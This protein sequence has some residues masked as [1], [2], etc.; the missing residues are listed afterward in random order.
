MLL[1]DGARMLSR[2]RS[3]VEAAARLVPAQY[4]YPILLLLGSCFGSIL[5]LLYLT[6]SA[7]DRMEAQREE[8]AIHSALNG[9]T[10]MVLHDL[11]DYAKWDDAVRH[12][13]AGS[14]DAW[15]DDNIT[16]FLG[17]IQGYDHVFVI[18]PQD[19]THYAFSHHVRA[20]TD[21]VAT[22]GPSFAASMK[23]VRGMDR[24]GAPI[25][26][27]FARHGDVLYLYAVAAVVPLTGKVSLPTGPTY[28]LAIAKRVDRTFLATIRSEQHLPPLT[29]DLDPT[30]SPA[31][32][33]GIAIH[34]LA[35]R[36]LATI[37]LV[38]DRPGTVLRNQVIPGFIAIACLALVAA[39]W[40]LRHGRRAIS[41]LHDSRAEAL[42]HANHDPLTNLPNRRL[43]LQRV[44][45]AL[46]GGRSVTLLY[47]DLDGFKDVNDLFG[48]AM[49][50]HLL[51]ET[52]DRLGQIT[53]HAD[54]IA[55]AGGD[56]FA[57]LL[58]DASTC[59]ADAIA[60][61][62]AELFR[63]PFAIDTS[64]VGIG[65]S[66]GVAQSADGAVADDELIR[67]ADV[68][69]YAAKAAGKNGWR[70][71]VPDMDREHDLR[72]SM[73][74]DLRGA[75]LRDEITVVFQPIVLAGSGEVVCVEALARW[76]HPNHGAVPPDV[77]IPLAEKSGLISDLG[78]QVL[79]RACRETRGR[80]IEL[81]V[82]L[83]PAQFWDRNLVDEVRAVL[84]ETGFP[85]ERLELELT[86]GCLLRRP[87]AA[88]AVMDDL[89]ALGVQLALDDFGA[90]FASLGYLRQLRFDRL[91]IDRGFVADAARDAEAAGVL[92]AIAA[93]GRSLGLQVTAEGVETATQ[94]AIVIAAGCD[95]AQ[96]WLYGYPQQ[97]AD[98]WGTP[99]S[100]AA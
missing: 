99:Q 26:S 65:V 47:L 73:E 68:A 40:I 66:I 36:E 90:G 41:A 71:Y 49:G 6:T 13:G 44:R 2:A 35:G 61:R 57:I 12:L 58:V 8:R 43:M 100:A 14:D 46:A 94:G 60:E 95:R 25:L 89:R 4:L 9:A 64:S 23:R 84:A 42:H 21:A 48:H 59:E 83:S 52:A 5:L 79:R 55:R 19:R 91:K 88:V 75:I 63:Q 93:L 50:D 51:C 69:M 62:I 86:E 53:R 74:N 11:Q 70:R 28:V 82:N 10:Q 38:Y 76:S 45:R 85:A 92:I 54:L 7:Q 96:G 15:I 37:D 98:L 87:E 3:K 97:A 56:E 22:L 77:F 31:D 81:A 24:T 72:K 67:R 80:D 17:T 1:A 34:D 32:E 16:A 20:T 27:G 30:A 39:G 18:D 33:D 78:R 29:L